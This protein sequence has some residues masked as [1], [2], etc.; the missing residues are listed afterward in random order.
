MSIQAQILTDMKSAMR[1]KDTIALGT[2]RALKSAILNVQKSGADVELDDADV[3]QLIRKQI[4]QR[5]DS[6][7]QFT[8]A[9]R[10]ELA[11]KEA[12]EIKV[13]ETYL[14]SAMTAEEIQTLVQ[15]AITSTGASSKAD[16]GK[17]MG[18]AQKKAEGRADGKALSSVVMQALSALSS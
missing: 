8:K 5:I 2:L 16:M 15:E 18:A 10:E 11:Q 6:E 3:L 13:L 4:K 14:P 7:E 9:G 1:S 17:V 12:A